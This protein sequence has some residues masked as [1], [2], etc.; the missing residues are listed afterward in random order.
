MRHG[1]KTAKLGRTTSHRKAMFRNMATSLILHGRIIT[2][3][4]KAK[5]IRPV[6]EKL[7][8]LG[9]KGDL[10]NR[11][12][13]ASFIKGEEA[14]AKL[15]GEIAE[16]CAARNGGYLRIYKAGY[17]KGDRAA[18][19]VIEF[20]DSISKTAT[21]LPANMEKETTSETAPAA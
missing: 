1:V 9:K 19:A 7:I 11:R 20:V 6:V 16:K 10:H 15:F 14:L 13:A 21:S 18:V 17:R 2:T 8:T 3:L 12:Q 5:A 4:P